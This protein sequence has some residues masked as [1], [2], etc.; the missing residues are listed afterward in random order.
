MFR[1]G[2]YADVVVGFDESPVKF[3]FWR[4]V[5]YIPMIVNEAGQWFTNEFDETGFTKAAPGDCEPMSD[6]GCWDSHVRIIEN[7]PARVVVNWRYRLTEPGHHWANYDSVT[8]WGDISDWD[9]YIYPDGVASKVMRWYSDKPDAWHEWDEQ[10]AVLSEGQHPEDVIEKTPVMVLVDST[11]KAENYDWNPDPPKPDFKGRLIQMI[12]YTGKYDPYTIQKFTH[13]DIYEGERTWYSV[14]PSWNH[15]PT[16][17]INS[18]GRNAS[19][20]DR[21]SHSSI[22]HLYWPEYRRVDGKTAYIEKILMEGM[23]DRPAASLTSLA[24]SWLNA[25]PVTGVSGGESQ[26]YDASHR[27]YRFTLGDG[28]LRFQITASDQ[29]PIHNL[30]FEV[31]NWKS[32]TTSANLKIDGVSQKPGPGFRQGV[33]IDTD[34]TFTLV[35]WAEIQSGSPR[36]FEITGE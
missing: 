11:G 4:G 25:P 26:G 20:P 33:K 27:A 1:F 19:F 10:I 23:T 12:C 5:S 30:C 18:S 16:A 22:S 28:P 35:L 17:Q 29:R 9:Y 8:G 3:I 34:G 13:G 31:R 2:K 24:K 6:K 36:N 32:R 15:W 7:N 21:A 14:F